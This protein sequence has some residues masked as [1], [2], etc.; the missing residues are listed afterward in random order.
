[1]YKIILIFFLLFTMNHAKDI[2]PITTLK[3]SGLVSDFVKDGDYLYVATD[4]GIVE[5]IDLFTQ[6]VVNQIRLEPIKTTMGNLVPTRIHSIDRYQGKTL[7]VSSGASAYRNVWIHDG[8]QLEKIID[9]KKHLMPKRAFFTAEGKVIL[10]TFGSDVTLYDTEENYKLYNT[11]ISESTMGGMVLS[12]DKQ[13]MVLSDESGTARLIDVNS[14][15]IEA[16]FSSEHVDNIYSIAYRNHTLITAGQDRRVGV[17]R[18]DKEAY[19]LK[20]DFLVYCVGL[21]PSAKTGIYSA[22]TDNHLQL[23]NTQDGSKTDRLIGHYA[24]PNKIMFISE[25][26][27]ISSGDEEKI[28]FWVL[29]E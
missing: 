17:Y 23:F 24:T 1:M 20:S 12:Q 2:Q 10:G 22:G 14:S 4:E 5:I 11:H 28:F 29:G 6:K 15:K 3:V 16:T 9:E 19:H 7:L 13:K 18:K 21:S 25:N 27:L 8:T 26:T